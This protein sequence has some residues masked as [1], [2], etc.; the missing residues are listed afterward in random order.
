MCSV[1]VLMGCE[2]LGRWPWGL[3]LMELKGWRGDGHFSRDSRR[4]VQYWGGAG[5]GSGRPLEFRALRGSSFIISR[6]QQRLE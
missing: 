1:K 4:G 2:V 6:S 5:A 3:V